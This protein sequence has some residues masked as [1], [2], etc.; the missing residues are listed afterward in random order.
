MKA[1]ELRALL[2]SLLSDA[3]SATKIALTA[4]NAKK[5]IVGQGPY[6]HRFH[7]AVVAITTTVKKVRPHLDGLELSSSDLAEF[8]SSLEVIKSTTAAGRDRTSA[9]RAL[10]LV[11][12]TAILP[13]AD[14]LSASPIPVTQFVI[15][16]DVVKGIRGYLK[17][18]VDQI[19]GCYEHRW[20]DACSVMIRK[21]A[22]IL[23]I[24]VFEKR[25]VAAEIK[26]PD[27]NFLMLS[28]LI[29]RIKAKTEW[30][31]GR[32]TK[33]CLD[34]LK[35]LGDRSAHNRHFLA[36]KQDVD[37]IISGLRVTVQ[38]LITLADYKRSGS[39]QTK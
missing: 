36:N 7:N 33:P 35:E 4:V 28:K 10:R 27:G 29:D 11:C 30:N 16:V 12:E 22:E 25:E 20:Y 3:D 6:A 32:E 2:T 19:N 31:L 8:D 17:E 13:R 37:N 24:A 9:V 26:G 38:E 18:I 39:S 15:P 1:P 23:I 14:G 34:K 5:S 21:L